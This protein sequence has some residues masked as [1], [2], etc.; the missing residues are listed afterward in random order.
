M[1]Y[2]ALV[3]TAYGVVDGFL[4]DW[5]REPYRWWTEADVHFE[6]AARLREQLRR[7]K[8]HKMIASYKGIVPGVRPVWSRITCKPLVRIGGA[9]CYPDIAIWDDVTGDPPDAEGGCNWPMLW[10]CEIK[11]RTRID[12]DGC[13]DMRKMETL[14][15]DGSLRYGCWV[16][17]N[18]SRGKGNGG[19]W[20]K[21]HDR[22]LW[23]LNATLPAAS[24]P[25]R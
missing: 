10:C 12:P 24:G 14:I 9:Y 25:A 22:R 8:R 16:Q 6:L 2:P 18:V 1:T 19:G 11:Y 23:Y 13:W 15:A 5:Q 4:R 7:A 3:S 20:Q 21:K 17:L